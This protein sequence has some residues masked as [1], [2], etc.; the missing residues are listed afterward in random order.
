MLPLTHEE[1]II[2]LEQIRWRG[3]PQCPYCGS[4][5]ASRYKRTHRYHFKDIAL[6]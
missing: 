3:Q 5:K 6:R 4:L 1:C 2:L